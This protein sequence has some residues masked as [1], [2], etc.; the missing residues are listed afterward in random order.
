MIYLFFIVAAIFILRPAGT[1]VII[2]IIKR[3]KNCKYN[4][5]E[6]LHRFN[7]INQWI[8]TIVGIFC[9][10]LL[11]MLRKPMHLSWFF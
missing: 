4:N 11:W 6:W 5:P 2:S 10:I 3:R 9:L 8:S 1:Q 7:T